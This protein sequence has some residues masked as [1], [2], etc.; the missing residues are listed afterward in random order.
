MTENTSSTMSFDRMRNMLTR[1]AEIRES[2]QQQIF[3]ALDE[4]HARM[5]PLESL[6]SVRKRL[7]ELP[8][9]TEVSVLA[10]RLDEALSKLEA[11]DTAVQGIS[12]AVDGLVDKLAKPFAQLDGRLDGVAGRFEG[13]AGRM[14]GL[15]DKLSHIHKRI[16]DLDGHLDK[17]DGK[18]EQL[19]GLVTG[20]LRERI[21]ALEASLRGRLDEVD[22]GVHEHLD[23]TR[24]G[25]QKSLTDSASALHGRLDETRDNLNSTRDGLHA[26]LTETKDSLHS[27]LA[28]TRNTVHGKLDEAREALHTALEETRDQV[29]AT[30]R[31]EALAQRLEQVTS[32]LDTMTNRLDAVEDDFTARLGELSGVVE[33]GMVKVGD[34]IAARPDVESLTSLVRKS[35]QESELRIGGQLDEAMATFAELILGGGSPTPPPP[36]TALPRPQR[37][38]RKNGPKPPGK[39]H[40]DDDEMAAEGA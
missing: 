37:R 8:D 1:A 36:P 23:G 24:E 27:S 9:R 34:T 21:E 19:P 31:L 14:D 30:D 15:E 5:S 39:E 4:I 16:D 29:D 18:T 12:R 20:P 6:G 7:S 28:D 10:E 13:V 2:E 3:D 22:E 35:N 32:R 40:M 17:Q 26:S 33:Q 25:L 11:Q 38:T